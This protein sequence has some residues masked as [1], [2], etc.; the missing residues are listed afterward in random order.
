M[1]TVC[2]TIDD[3]LENVGRKLVNTWSACK[4]DVDRFKCPVHRKAIYLSRFRTSVGKDD[5][6]HTAVKF[7][8]LLHVSAVISD[9]EGEYLLEAGE[10]CGIDYE[11]GSQEFN[12]TEK[13]D[14]LVAKLKEFCKIN[15]L[16]TRPGSVSY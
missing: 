4:G 14:E 2:P 15:K 10:D 11:D 9:S 16:E 12:G 1:R 7:K 3:F 8:V 6:Q 5:N 13:A